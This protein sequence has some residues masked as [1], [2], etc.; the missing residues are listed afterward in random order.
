MRGRLHRDFV[1]KFGFLPA[2][3]T[4]LERPVWIHAVS[5]G[6]AALAAKLSARI[7]G[8]FPDIPVVVSTTTQT[9]NDM[10]RKS[11]KGVIDGV[12]YY[13]LDMRAVVSR[14]VRLLKPRLYVMI[15]TELWPNLLE[16]LCSKHIPVVLAN[17]R[18]SDASFA[19]YKKIR[20]VTKRILRGIDR[21][22]MQS[23]KDAERI[24]QLGAAGGSI[25]ITGN[26]KFDEKTAL[27]APAGFDK[28]HLGFREGD[29]IIVAGSTH[30]PE[31]AALVDIYGEL[32]KGQSNLKLVLAP[33]HVQR[34]DA[35]KMYFE[36]AGLGYRC[37]SDVLKRDSADQG[38]Y[39]VLLVDTI[40]HL[41][42]IYSVATVIFIGGSLAA[43]G[44]Q[45]PIE[46]ARWGKAVVFGPHMF[47]FREVADIFLESKAAVCVKDVPR[48]KNE[49][50]RFL[51]DPEARKQIAG[52]ARKV[53][54]ENSGAAGRTMEKIESILSGK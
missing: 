46:A 54:E 35:I 40:G 49:L 18:I 45:N 34:T 21:F 23:E 14:A 28:E 36:K 6:E 19:K 11:G 12:F 39:D 50:R 37:F 33:R 32:R 38:R 31:E 41:K 43:K 48:L 44:G 2:D 15:E 3:V 4:G 22:C 9:G 7:K 8:R 29:E 13:P 53:I 47:H 24:R 25:S 20:F 51:E 5:V 30:F 26:I 27:A 52:N 17:G 42:D 16:E 10:I 1:Q